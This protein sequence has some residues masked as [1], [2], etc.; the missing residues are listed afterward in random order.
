[1]KRAVFWNDEH[2]WMRIL[3]LMVL[4]WSALMAGSLAWN[5]RQDQ[6]NILD[7]AEAAARANISKDISF[8]NWAAS[9]GGVYV[10]PSEHTPPNPYLKVPDRDV[11]TTTGKTLTLMNPAY[12]LR[13]M[14]SDFP[15]NSGTRSHITSLKPINPNN[16]PD[17]WEAR[18]LRAFEQGSKEMLE[19]QQIDSRPYLR[20]MQPF[21]VEQGCLKCHEQQG[22][23]L[24]DIRG[25][26]SST[27]PLAPFLANAQEARNHLV[28][29]HGTIWLIGLAGLA[30][31]GVSFR[32]V[33]RLETLVRS[34]A[35]VEESERRFRAVAE[36]AND[37]IINADS[38]SKVVEWN[39]GAE[40]LFGYTK[41]E[42][43]GQPLTVL[44]PERFRNLHS[45]GLARVVA[46]GV[47]HVIGKT[48][49]LAGLRKDGS[50][51]PLEFS[52]AQW[53]TTEGQFFTAII[54]DITERKQVEAS[55][56]EQLE[57]LRHWHEITSGR[58]KRI[59]AVKHEVNEL[60]GKSGQPPRYPSAES[61]DQTE[62]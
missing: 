39:P 21:I 22:Y 20:L 8:R 12:M 6:Q 32:R 51:F 1:M 44:M 35:A 27:V 33:R 58:E 59:L 2:G 15:D 61:Q 43:I 17:A 46:G 24:G 45:A 30:W 31:L 18:A 23:K 9:H 53:Q 19:A 55:L 7:S 50:E 49:E 56:A 5:M 4:I 41:A 42:I 47:P 29:S 54:R 10:P 48:I 26:I 25:G 62:G 3:V 34:A 60:L 36:S 52:L 16:A 11:V 14:Q 57:E 28:I 40:R 13:Q 38:A 37:A